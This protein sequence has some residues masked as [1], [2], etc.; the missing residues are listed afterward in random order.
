MTQ[1]KWLLLLMGFP[2][3][4]E[5]TVIQGLYTLAVRRAF[6][7][8]LSAVDIEVWLVRC[9]MCRASLGHKCNIAV[10]RPFD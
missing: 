9:A 5:L 7:H 1:M 4:Y 2:Q 6:E 10:L 3:T 8:D